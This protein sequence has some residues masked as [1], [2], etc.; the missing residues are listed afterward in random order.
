MRGFDLDA[1]TRLLALDSERRN[2]RVAES[3]PALKPSQVWKDR[4][5][6]HMS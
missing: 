6:P 5:E 2:R 4:F 1:Y 3:L